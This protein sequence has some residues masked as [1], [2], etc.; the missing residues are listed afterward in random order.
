FR[1]IGLVSDAQHKVSRQGNKFGSFT[2][3]DY[4]GK[5]EMLVWSDDYVKYAHYLQQG[6]TLF[7]TGFFKQRYNK[8]E[9]EFKIT[10]VSL[11]ETLKKSLTKQL[12][13][14]LNPKNVSENMVQFFLKNFH[15]HPGKSGLK[16]ILNEPK[17]NWKISLLTIDT[18]FEMN[19]EM[20]EYLESNPELEVQV[21]TH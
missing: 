7:I 11:V 16:I 15:T 13:V 6:T 19:D 2:I 17:N 10:S 5:T 4:S 21:L 20:T 14:E 1:L 12:Q 9:F 8:T 18:G 3:E